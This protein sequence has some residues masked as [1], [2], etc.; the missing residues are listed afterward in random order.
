MK[1]ALLS[2]TKSKKSYSCKA[3]EMYSESRI[4]RR[5]YQYAKLICDEVYILSAKYGL[6]SE[7]DII[8]PY[9]ETLNKKSTQERRLWSEKVRLNLGKLY[10]LEND[11]FLV[12]AGKSYNEFLL[13]YL[14]K[15]ELPLKGI[16]IFYW[17]PKLEELIENTLSNKEEDTC[18]A[19]HE[20]FNGMSRLNWSDISSVPF[21]NGIYVMFELGEKYKGMDRIVRIGTHRADGRLIERL[22]DHF[23]KENKDGSIFRKN[24]GLALLHKNKEP[25]ESIWA[26]DTS[27]PE[28]RKSYANELNLD[29]KI[30]IEK[31]V[32]NFLQS[33]ISF[34]CFRVDT[35][36]ERLRIEEGLI[37]LLNQTDDYNSSGTWLGN[38]N[39]KNEISNSGLWN[40]QGLNGKPLSDREIAALKA[41]IQGGHNTTTNS[42][43]TIKPKIKQQ[44]SIYRN[45]EAEKKYEIKSI[46]GK[47]STSNIVSFIE[48]IMKQSRE[49]GWEYV[50]IVSGDIHKKM[51]LDNKMPSVCNAMYKLKKA[52]D[53]L[54]NTTPSGKSST[55]KIRY[56]L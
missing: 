18:K 50:D 48:N 40:T 26:L 27:K 38:H 34:I 23:I 44:S 52:K 31:E 24:V 13:P 1:I 17:I 12:L 54:L 25:Y 49:K 2:C 22:K 39:P 11:E 28:I 15:Y 41:G 4:F 8:E 20:L 43:T 35:E 46:A 29:K 6:I 47:V 9:N 32:T 5:A 21:S 56:F 42:E 30:S 10:S 55:I 7:E 3:S 45:K 51:I 16:N 36:Q 53:I 33:N 19:I 37:A 14:N